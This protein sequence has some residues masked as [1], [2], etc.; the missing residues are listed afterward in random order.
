MSAPT[1]DDP[2][3]GATLCGKWTIVRPLG[4]GGTSLVYEA[5]HRNGKPVAVKMLRPELAHKKD[6]RT[7][8]L[9]EGYLANRVAHPGV[10]SVLDD[11]VDEGGRPF[12]VTE[13]LR[14]ETLERRWKGA[15]RR[16]DAADALRVVGGVLEVLEAAHAAGVVHRDVKPGNVFLDGDGSVKLLDFG[17]ARAQELADRS[18]STTRSDATMGTPAFMAPEQARG[19][20]GEVDHRSDLWSV[21]ATLYALLTGSYVHARHSGNETLVAAATQRAPSVALLRPDLPAALV[22]AVDRALAFEKGERYASAADMRRALAEA[23]AALP[24][25][26]TEGDLPPALSLARHDST[27]PPSRSTR[28]ETEG[29]FG[30]PSAHSETAGSF[31]NRSEVGAPSV[32]SAPKNRRRGAALL[33]LVMA[34]AGTVLAFSFFAPGLRRNADT[35][36]LLPPSMNTPTI[37]AAPPSEAPP[38]AQASGE[39]ALALAPSAG[40]RPS[41]P[42][43]SPRGRAEAPPRRPG[44]TGS[45]LAG[46]SKASDA[47]PAGAPSAAALGGAPAALAAP[48]AT[49]AAEPAPRASAAS[50]LRPDAELLDRR[51]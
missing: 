16:L 1:S 19:H 22:E 34:A 48:S 9:R 21:G 31:A 41:P 43:V 38:P 2:L 28:P 29:S 13:L 11:D 24:P 15:G 26:T 14:G 35:S 10:V 40:D 8:F 36:S 3:V 17:L 25:A 32:P 4:A 7:R 42:G 30:P 12:L 45:A 37:V 49:R 50:P 18:A 20:W 27:S 33:A 23:A 47:P 46:R 44:G 6:A 51:K 39:P 5:R